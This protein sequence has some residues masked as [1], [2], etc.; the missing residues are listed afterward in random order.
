MDAQNAPIRRR[1]EGVDSTQFE[2]GQKPPIDLGEAVPGAKPPEVPAIEA[3]HA[4]ALV[5]G[6][7]EALAFNEEPV[8]VMIYPSSEENAPLTVP[9]WVNGRGAEVFLNGKWTVMGHLPVGVKLITRRKYAEVLLRAKRDKIST[10]HQGTEVERPTNRVSR[11]S[12]AV[13]NIQI[14]NDR[15]PKGIEWVRRCMA[16]PG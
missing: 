6:R 14:V 7:A 13:A 4:D 9:C 16:Q 8:E 11:I 5:D 2:M 3:I 1:R 15:N 10:E 12:S